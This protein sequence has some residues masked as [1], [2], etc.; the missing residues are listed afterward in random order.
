M[1][2]T[3]LEDVIVVA[4]RNPP[5]PRPFSDIALA[6]GIG[7]A[8]IT[9]GVVWLTMILLCNFV[10]SLKDVKPQDME[11]IVMGTVFGGSAFGAGVGF[12]IGAIVEYRTRIALEKAKALLEREKWLGRLSN[13]QPMT[14]IIDFDK[15][16]RIMDAECIQH[17]QKMLRALSYMP[18]L[19]FLE[20]W[21]SFKMAH[22]G[23]QYRKVE[24]IIDHMD[25]CCQVEH[26]G[27]YEPNYDGWE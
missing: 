7:T 14:T 22:F 8:L 4:D 2:K 16:I 3:G 23:L 12:L 18:R 25:F 26:V 20:A 13:D 19:G 6:A 5:S 17:A 21:E 27:E 15:G 24:E 10:F 11:G 1:A 9:A